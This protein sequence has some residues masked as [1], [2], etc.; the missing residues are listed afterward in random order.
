MSERRGPYADSRTVQESN[1]GYTV[2][3]PKEIAERSELEKGDQMF[4]IRSRVA[5]EVGLSRRR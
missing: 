2:S 4:W 1:G 3:I 5:F